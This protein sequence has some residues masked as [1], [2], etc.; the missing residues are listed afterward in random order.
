MKRTK[1]IIMLL[2]AILC[3]NVACEKK[4]L[5]EGNYIGDFYGTQLNSDGSF[6]E[7]EQNELNVSIELSDITDSSVVVN[8]YLIEPLKREGKDS[9]SG[10]IAGIGGGYFIPPTIKGKYSNLFGK[11]SIEGSYTAFSSTGVSI[12]GTFEI[13]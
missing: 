7:F 4:K 8:N 13:K 10:I 2:C 6:S 3:F 1:L 12:Q 5:K 9:I 11:I